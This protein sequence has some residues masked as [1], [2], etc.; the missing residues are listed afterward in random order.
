MPN[1]GGHV[2]DL[3]ALTN[4]RSSSGRRLHTARPIIGRHPRDTQR[5]GRVRKEAEGAAVRAAEVFREKPA[6]SLLT[7]RAVASFSTCY[8][9]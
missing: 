5:N 4:Q 7:Q 1:A 2:L 8:R 3:A 9:S 6:N